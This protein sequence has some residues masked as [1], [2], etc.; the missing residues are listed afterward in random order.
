MVQATRT[1]TAVM[2]PYLR[3]RDAPEAIAWLERAFGFQP[4]MVMP[5]EDGTIAHA[6]VRLGDGFIMLASPH[7]PVPPR[8]PDPLDAERSLYVNIAD[9]DAHYARALAAGATI[10]RPLE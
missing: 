8:Q 4:H 7:G 10:A 1:D 2:Y 6:E 3:Y 5:N 9:V